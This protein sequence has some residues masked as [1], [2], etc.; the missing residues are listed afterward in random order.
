MTRVPAL[1]L[2]RWVL[3]LVGVALL[4]AIL[5]FLGP[6]LTVLAPIAVRAGII[7]LMLLAWAGANLLIDRRRRARDAALAEGVADADPGAAASAE[8]VAALRERLAQSMDL[9]RRARGTR[10]YL[11]EQPWYVIIGPPGAGKTT[12]LLNAG[13]R[14]PLAAEAGHAVP[15]VGGTRLCD[16]WFTD[17]AVL[18]D[19][20][21]RYT[22]QDSD[23]AVDRA[24]WEGFLDLLKRTRARQPLNG[25]IVAIAITDIAQPDRDARL[26]HARAVRRRVKEITE[27]LGVRVPVYAVFTKA[28]LLA[29]FTEY[30]DD[31]DR[32]RRGQVWGVTFPLETGGQG[33]LER[34]GPAFN[35]LIERLDTRLFERLQAERSPD[36]RALLAM[37]PAQVASLEQPLKEF[38]AEAFGGSRL[39]PAP[40]LRGVYLTSGT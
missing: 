34:F 6:L 32:E 13:L 17:E 20:A 25:V 1:L 28:D 37:F 39:D 35:A 15:G 5:W 31:L 36:R 4:A 21:G 38:L 12:A 2:S 14:F 10:G 29:G 19:T 18:I 23:A 11:Y 26:A 3:S 30:F 16:W 40:F 24:G 8:E 22:T 9:L 27:R 33:P 7:L